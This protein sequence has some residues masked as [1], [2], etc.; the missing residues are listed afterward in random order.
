LH[1]KSLLD[2]C[3]QQQMAKTL[4][5][6]LCRRIITFGPPTAGKLSTMVKA[7]M[8]FTLRTPCRRMARVGVWPNS[9]LT[10]ALDTSEW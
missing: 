10:T 4:K 3:Y 8:K 2:W 6:F 7:K 1:K 9:F 5:L